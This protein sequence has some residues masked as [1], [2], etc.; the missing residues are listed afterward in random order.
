MPPNPNVTVKINLARLRANTQHI[1]HQTNSKI[2]AVVKA[3]AYGL[4][5]AKVAETIADLVE[6]FYVFTP[7]EAIESDLYARTG[8]R[9]IAL[10]ADPS[11]LDQCIAHHIHPAVWSLPAARLF[12]KAQPALSI[13]C[14][15]GRFACPSDQAGELLKAASITEAFT[16]ASTPAQASIFA[17]AT[18]A[19]PCFRHAAGSALLNDPASRFDAVRPGLALYAG[20]ATVT[21]NLVDARDSTGKAGYTQFQTPRYGVILIG[22]SNGL[23]PGPCTVNGNPRRI[24]EVGMQS[25]F[26]DL[27]PH[28]RAGDPVTLLGGSVT[29]AALAREWRSTPHEVLLQLTRAAP[30]HYTE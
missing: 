8:K 15:Q 30:R 29:E 22:Y 23:R 18:A 19:H 7:L 11:M 3:N 21:C 13:D 26:I 9:S 25:A 16:H 10:L 27:G 2:I 14:G 4:G 1:A 28:D 6:A 12:H 24:L 20:V 17:N 5:A